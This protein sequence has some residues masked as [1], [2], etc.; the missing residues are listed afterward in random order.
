VLPEPLGF[1]AMQSIHIRIN[2]SLSSTLKKSWI[3]LWRK[4]I[5]ITMASYFRCNFNTVLHLCSG[6]S[7]GG[8]LGQM[9]H[10]KPVA[11]LCHKC[12]SFW[13]PWM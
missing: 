3:R 11:P 7:S 2:S 6:G 9:S 12:A 5:F 1:T 13:C 10:P 4:C 8:S